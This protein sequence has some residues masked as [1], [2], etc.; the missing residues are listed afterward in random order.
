MHGNQGTGCASCRRWAG[1]TLA[2]LQS[3]GWGVNPSPRATHTRETD[4]PGEHT[5]GNTE[6]QWLHPR[7]A[8]T[9]VREQLLGTRVNWRGAEASP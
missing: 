2:P 6:R 9:A 1:A 5:H 7:A 4:R 3:R 8:P